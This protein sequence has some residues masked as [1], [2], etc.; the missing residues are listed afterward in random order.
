[1][2]PWE[3]LDVAQAP[4]G[5]ELTLHRRG[6]EFMIR[7]DG[8]ELMSSRRHGSE[9]ALADLALAELGGRKGPKVMIGGLGVG[10]TLQA[11]LAA[12]DA[13]A[14]VVQCEL[15]PAVVKWNQELLG[16]LAGQPLRDPRTSI[17]VGDVF[18]LIADARGEYDAILLDVDNGPD[19][20]IRP[21]N[22][23]LYRA[24][25][26]L[27]ARAALTKG[28]VLA[29]WSAAPDDGFTKAMGRA[30]FRVLVKNARGVRGRGV[31]HTI[32]LGIRE[33]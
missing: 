10:Y 20:L 1:M 27:A 16:D 5:G 4:G 8:A 31:K 25:G 15:S 14:R 21:D 24:E 30:G 32:W 23:R 2:I 12:C 6:A 17:H 3:Q 13:A 22:E 11:A 33:R 7:I 26:L 28:G 9:A 19:A 18:E 29:V